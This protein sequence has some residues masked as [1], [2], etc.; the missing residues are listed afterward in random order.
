MRENYENQLAQLNQ[1]LTQMGELCEQIIDYSSR[2]LVS[3][4]KDLAKQ[5]KKVGGEIDEMERSIETV[6]MR[7]LLRQQP[8]ARDLRVVSAGLK[9]ITDLERIGDQA[10][11]I[12]EIAE[13]IQGASPDGHDIQLMAQHAA[14][15]VTDSVDTPISVRMWSWQKMY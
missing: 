15:M 5:V 10:E 14:S 11:D 7:L 8:V 12:A 3:W 6:C 4:D 1:N 9:I 2:L 13:S